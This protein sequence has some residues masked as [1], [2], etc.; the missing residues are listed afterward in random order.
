MP[1]CAVPNELPV[2]LPN[3]NDGLFYCPVKLSRGHRIGYADPSVVRCDHLD[4]CRAL[5]ASVFNHNTSTRN[6]NFRAHPDRTASEVK[7]YGFP[8][9]GYRKNY[10]ADP[11][12]ALLANR[13]KE[14]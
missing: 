9:V 5:N 11:L 6:T 7:A 3:E 1:L 13:R 14:G 8:V 4:E 2:T 10:P 12:L